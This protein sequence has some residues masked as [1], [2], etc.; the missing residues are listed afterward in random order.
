M[1][2]PRESDILR[3]ISGELQD[4]LRAEVVEHVDGCSICAEQV[5]RMRELRDL[6]GE[7][8]VDVAGHEVDRAVLRAV[9][10]QPVALPFDRWSKPWR[11][12]VPL[13]AAASFLLAA[14]IG[15]SVSQSVQ[16]SAPVD[17]TELAVVDEPAT[18]ESVTADL[19]LEALGGGAATGLA[20]TLLDEN[21]PAFQ[22]EQG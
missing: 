20:A 10:S 17:R 19:S 16:Q 8:R 6:M 1:A 15:W 2:C 3:M 22:E 5:H 13:R 9:G 21:Q 7:W 18:P 11:W 12:P 4:S 14:G